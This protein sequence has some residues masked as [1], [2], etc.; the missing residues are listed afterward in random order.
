MEGAK[1]LTASQRS[2]RDVKNKE[3]WKNAEGASTKR[4]TDKQAKPGVIPNPEE[5][6][7]AERAGT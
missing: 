5:V 1:V 6:L 7:K 4:Q 3:D 2:E